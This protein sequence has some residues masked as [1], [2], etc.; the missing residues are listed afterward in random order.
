MYSHTR[1]IVTQHRVDFPGDDQ[2][3]IPRTNPV[4]FRLASFVPKKLRLVGDSNDCGGGTIIS[5]IMFQYSHQDANAVA[6]VLNE[7]H[8]CIYSVESIH[9]GCTNSSTYAVKSQLTVRIFSGGTNVINLDAL[10]AGSLHVPTD[11]WS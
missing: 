2:Q 9:S 8:Q 10:E 5:K 6:Y 4:F 7:P 1:N 3:R 11:R